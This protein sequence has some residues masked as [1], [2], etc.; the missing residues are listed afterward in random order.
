MRRR[1]AGSVLELRCGAEWSGVETRAGGETGFIGSGGGVEEGVDGLVG[2]AVWSAG[3]ALSVRNVMAVLSRHEYMAAPP[4]T[5]TDAHDQP[6]S[7]TST[8]PTGTVL[9]STTQQPTL[10]RPR[11]RWLNADFGRGPDS[12]IREPRCEG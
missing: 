9:A 3:S 2:R 5:P 1:H 11:S 10:R 6:W 4:P 7:A 12:W 8:A